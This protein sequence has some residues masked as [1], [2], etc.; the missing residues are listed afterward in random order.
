MKKQTGQVINL[1]E[2]C[3]EAL[4]EVRRVGLAKKEHVYTRLIDYAQRRGL[5]GVIEIKKAR[6]YYEKNRMEEYRN[7][8]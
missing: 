2:M 7:K 5:Y 1:E 4:D 8:K 3:W 6:K